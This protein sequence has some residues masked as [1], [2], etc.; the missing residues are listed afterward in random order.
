VRV[1]P[2]FIPA[3][4][5][6]HLDRYEL[7]DSAGTF[8]IANECGDITAYVERADG[9]RGHSF[10]GPVYDPIGF[11]NAC[12]RCRI[13]DEFGDIAWCDHHHDMTESERRV[14]DGLA[15]LVGWT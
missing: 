10:G 12:Q 7:A 4:D 6:D 8:G 1:G 3:A 2:R 15:R 9:S 13:T 5:S 11:L 14:A